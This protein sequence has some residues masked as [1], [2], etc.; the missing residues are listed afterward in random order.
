MHNPREV[1]LEAAYRSLQYLKRIPRNDI[2]FKKKK[3]TRLLLEIYTD[4]DYTE[5]VVDKRSTTGNSTFLR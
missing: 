2:I 5:L 1:H 4:A 3:K